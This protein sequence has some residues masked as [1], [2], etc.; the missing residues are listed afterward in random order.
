MLRP[1]VQQGQG[2]DDDDDEDVYRNKI[3]NWTYLSCNIRLFLYG[4]VPKKW[5]TFD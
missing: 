4:T 3:Q 2:I 5:Q 1:Y